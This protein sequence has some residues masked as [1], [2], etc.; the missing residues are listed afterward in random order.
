MPPIA[1]MKMATPSM[2][3]MQVGIASLAPGSTRG[4]VTPQAE[5]VGRAAAAEDMILIFFPL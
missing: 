2:R 1:R 3:A 4:K 5:R